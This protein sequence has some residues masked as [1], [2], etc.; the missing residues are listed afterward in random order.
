MQRR[1]FLKI[2]TGMAVGA[3]SGMLGGRT[4]GQTPTA[5]ASELPVTLRVD[6]QAFQGEWKPLWR[7]F[8]YDEPNFTT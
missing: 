7:F 4:A 2:G 3:V 6:A 5:A 1:R 8:G